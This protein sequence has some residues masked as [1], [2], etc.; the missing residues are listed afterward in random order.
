MQSGLGETVVHG[1]TRQ[2]NEMSGPP[3][4]P[5]LAALVQPSPVKR[6]LGIYDY[7]FHHPSCTLRGQMRRVASSHVRPFHPTIPWHTVGRRLGTALRYHSATRGWP[8]LPTWHGL[9]PWTLRTDL[10]GF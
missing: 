5:G 10:A 8:L 7:I 6:L 9:D 1:V 4:S 3:R 2:T